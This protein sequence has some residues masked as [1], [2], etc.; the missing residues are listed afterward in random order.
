MNWKRD[1]FLIIPFTAALLILLIASLSAFFLLPSGSGISL[2][3]RFSAL[4]GARFFGSLISVSAILF[5]SFFYL[6]ASIFLAWFI[7][8]RRPHAAYLL[9]VSSLFFSILILIYIG[10]IIGIN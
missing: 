8:V 10:V 6:A 5:I 1:P 7:Y 9:S 4:G 2:I 3:T